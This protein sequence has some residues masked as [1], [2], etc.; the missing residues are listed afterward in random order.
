VNAPPTCDLRA[1]LLLY[2]QYAEKGNPG[3]VYHNPV[4]ILRDIV[5]T[6]P[7]SETSCVTGTQ[8][9]SVDNL[10]PTAFKFMAAFRR[11]R[12]SLTPEPGQSASAPTPSSMPQEVKRKPAVLRR[13]VATPRPQS[14]ASDSTAPNTSSMRSAA[15]AAE[16]L[17]S[18][19]D[20][21][22][23]VASANPTDTRM[24]GSQLSH[25]CQS[26]TFR[27]PQLMDSSVSGHSVT[28]EESPEIRSQKKRN[29]DTKSGCAIQ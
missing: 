29:K 12:T 6:S 11:S 19:L 20:A 1:Q 3:S 28:Q 23:S 5:P 27:S 9:T 25:G 7:T 2:A 13:K 4:D 18:R 15:T 26:E 21:A 14:L 10:P 8:S 24:T 16:S 22:A 17:S